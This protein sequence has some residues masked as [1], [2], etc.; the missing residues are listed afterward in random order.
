M[1]LIFLSF[2]YI[3]YD[4]NTI[5]TIYSWPINI[6]Y[7]KS[8][9]NVFLLL[10][11]RTIKSDDGGTISMTLTSEDQARRMIN[12]V[13]RPHLQR[14]VLSSWYKAI[15]LRKEE[16]RMNGSSMCILTL[17]MKTTLFNIPDA[18]VTICSS[19]QHQRSF[20][21]VSEEGETSNAGSL[22]EMHN[23]LGVRK[24]YQSIP[25]HTSDS[26]HLFRH[27]PNQ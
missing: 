3:I 5:L 24:G 22:L 20:T 15:T 7:T 14:I 6:L 27:L 10:L 13:H 26:E 25:H 2:E 21:H 4:L 12:L 23:W 9:L 18:N 1:S 19:T 11:S 8:L 17:E 16:G